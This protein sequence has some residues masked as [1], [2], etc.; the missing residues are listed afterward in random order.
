MFRRYR[1]RTR[2]GMSINPRTPQ[3]YGAV[4]QVE[5]PVY[6]EV[7]RSTTGPLNNDDDND[8]ARSR[9]TRSDSVA[10]LPMVS[11]NENTPASSFQRMIAADPL[12][13]EGLTED[14]K[15][16]FNALRQWGKMH[17]KT[18]RKEEWVEMTLLK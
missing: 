16:D 17:K 4:Y 13:D 9:R 10:V 5:N 15:R 6:D 12:K 3:P 8:D 2:R 18:H 11:N 1:H 14:E 7:Y